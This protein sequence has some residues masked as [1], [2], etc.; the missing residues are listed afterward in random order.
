MQ[1]IIISLALH[2]IFNKA[3]H[4]LADVLIDEA[5]SC[6]LPINA[7]VTCEHDAPRRG[8]KKN[9]NRTAAVVLAHEWHC[10][11]LGMTANQA[12]S[13]LVSLLQYSEKRAVT[14]A[15]EK[16][17]K[18]KINGKFVLYLHSEAHKTGMALLLGDS[19]VIEVEPNGIS[20]HGPGWIWHYGQQEAIYQNQWKGHGTRDEPLDDEWLTRMRRWA[21]GEV[22]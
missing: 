17:K 20:F 8:R 15:R 16:K 19:A 14:R 10:A 4:Q 21:K 9:L 22:T 7:W 11:C 2:R 13:E 3:G 18:E 6:L 5:N 12:D 1:K